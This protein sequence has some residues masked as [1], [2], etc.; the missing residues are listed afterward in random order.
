V[1]VQFRFKQHF[2]NPFQSAVTIVELHVWQVRSSIGAS[3]IQQL[4]ERHEELTISAGRAEFGQMPVAGSR[5]SGENHSACF[6]FRLR[7]CPR[8]E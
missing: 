1:R 2:G 7:G 8:W 6:S 3:R 5:Q 4:P